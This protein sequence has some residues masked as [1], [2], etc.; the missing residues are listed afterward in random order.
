MVHAGRKVAQRQ[1]ERA[2][3]S[4]HEHDG[5]AR[6]P[7]A[8]RRRQ[9][10]QRQTQRRQDGRYPRRDRRRAARKRLQDL[11]EQHAVRL[12]QSG[13]PELHEERAHHHQPAVAAVRRLVRQHAAQ[14]PIAAAK[15]LRQSLVCSERVCVWGGVAVTRKMARTPVV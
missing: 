6:E 10:R 1:P 2:E 3:Q 4:A 8:Q 7:L 13:H 14:A 9:R 11:H 12:D 5:A 15:A